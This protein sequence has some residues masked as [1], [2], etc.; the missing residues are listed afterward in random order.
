MEDS[1]QDNPL[2]GLPYRQSPS[3]DDASLPGDTADLL[4]RVI[5]QSIEQWSNDNDPMPIHLEPLLSVAKRHAGMP[6]TRDPIAVELVEAAL[7]DSLG[8]GPQEPEQWRSISRQVAET[9]VINERSFERME[10]LWQR[11]QRAVSQSNQMS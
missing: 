11:L 3:S 10:R 1:T 4:Q 6:L 8:R 5:D 7:V 2:A 9:L